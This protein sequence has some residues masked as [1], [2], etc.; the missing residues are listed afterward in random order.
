MTVSPR[1]WRIAAS[2]AI[3]LLAALLRLGHLGDR[4][5]DNDEVA[6]TTWASY[7][8]DRMMAAVRHDA[9]HP[10]ADYILQF[11]MGR[12]GATEWVRRM[13]SVILGTATVA[14]VIVLG[15][16]W[17]SWGAGAA[18]ALLLAMS[19]VHVFYSQQIRPY[20]TALC[21]VFVSLCALEYYARTQN[22]RW[23]WVWA[24]FV[25]LAGATLYFG[26]MV[27]AI[28]GITRIFLDRRGSL[29]W[30]W[31]RLP[32]VIL[33][34]VVL[35][36]PWLQVIRTASRIP[37]PDAVAK[38]DW[39][40]W[41][42]RLQ[43]FGTGSDRTWEAVSLGS[44]A[45]WLLVVVGIVASV[46]VRLFR[47]PAAMFVIGSLIVTLVLH[48]HP[49]Y[50][51]PRYYMP[52]WIAS[53]LL[54]GAAVYWLSRHWAAAPVAVAAI[55][56]FAVH[57][58]VKIDE[59]YR[60]DRADWREVAGYVHARIKPGDTL[61]VTSTWVIRNFGHYWHP[62]PPVPNLKIDFYKVSDREIAGPA[63]IVT[64]G[65]M[66][67]EAARAAPL[68]ARWP[69]SEQAE[70]RYLRPGMK[71]SMREPICPD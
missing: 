68:M 48:I 5:L 7:S 58:G 11:V 67:R 27:A 22:K 46:R 53:F 34:W 32:V 71:M 25:W 62:L 64:G 36:A 59:Y 35:Y 50:P 26:G 55:I 33:I 43:T 1:A 15:T 18:A 12:M 24:G 9:V 61:V 10:P 41:E 63:W 28:G 70:V 52:P 42:W 13:P 65:C 14:L 30:L 2:I 16:M 57:A 4:A 39:D 29:Q 23:A 37:S 6:E 19:P 20:A 31:R 17:A 40:W 44:W 69:R 38:Y 60:W 21:W 45:Y 51:A 3:V 66:P 47:V 56:T 49:H 8:F 54:A